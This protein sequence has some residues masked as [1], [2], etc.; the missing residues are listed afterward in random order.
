LLRPFGARE[1]IWLLSF[2]LLTARTIRLFCD[3]SLRSDLALGNQ[4]I[5]Y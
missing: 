2:R 5:D 1:I 4:L 3:A